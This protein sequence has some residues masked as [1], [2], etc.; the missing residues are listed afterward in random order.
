MDQTGEESLDQDLYTDLISD[1]LH[2]AQARL[3]LPVSQAA[4]LVERSKKHF[5]AEQ[6]PDS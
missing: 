1:L 3:G 5:L 2:H 4:A 6:T